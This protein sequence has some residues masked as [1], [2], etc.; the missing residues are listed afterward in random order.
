MRIRR[1][2]LSALLVLGLAFGLPVQA[3]QMALVGGMSGATSEDAMAP[4]GDCRHCEMDARND[5]AACHGTCLVMPALLL[6][7]AARPISATAVLP[8]E[9]A[10]DFVRGPARVPDPGPPKAVAVI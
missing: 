8:L 1:R 4:S 6:R 9:R 3:A 10:L 5:M 7:D 2:L